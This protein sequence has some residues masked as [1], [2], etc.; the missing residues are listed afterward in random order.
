VREGKH[1]QR[2]EEKSGSY[3]ESQ[4]LLRGE[5][6]VDG[7]G[8]LRAGPILRADQ[9][10][11]DAALAV[12][13]VSVWVHRGA[14]GGGDFFG[15]VAEIRVVHAVLGEELLVE[16]LRVVNADADHGAAQRLDA[17]LERDEGIGF[18]D[19]GRAGGEPEVEE[20]DFAAEVGKVHWL[21]VH[22]EGEVRGCRAGEA[23]LALAIIGRDEEIEQGRDEKK[24][25]G[26]EEFA[27][28]SIVPAKYS[29]EKLGE[30]V[31]NGENWR[32]D[33]RMDRRT[34][35]WTWR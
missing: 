12:D 14:V 26:C 28:Q 30:I 21:A 2:G 24:D 25:E 17:L 34:W 11:D 15:D 10:A 16:F 5:D 33:S 35:R 13:D 6:V 32:V 4:K 29:T 20:D 27:F 19:A 8:H 18:F 22:G 23:R 1:S 9:L 31:K 7:V 3:R